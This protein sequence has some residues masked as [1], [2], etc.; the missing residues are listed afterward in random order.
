MKVAHLV[1][2]YPRVSHSFIRREILALEAMGVEVERISIRPCNAPLPDEADR[3]ESQRTTAILARGAGSLL[4]STFGT[5]FSAPARFFAA[6]Q[7]AFRL[8]LRSDRGVG[9]HLAY[10]AEACA[11]KSMLAERG[12]EHVHAHFGTNSAAVAMLCRMLGGPPFS[13]TVHGPEEFDK[14]EFLGLSEK[15]S[16][17][18]FV[19]A[20]SD[21]GRS[22]LMRWC[23]FAEWP[24]IHV[25]RC[26]VDE[27]FLKGGNP[28]PTGDAIVCVGRLCEQKGQGLLI[29]A[30]ARL[31][32]EGAS[33]R[34]ILVGDGP[35]RK[36]LEALVSERGL[37]GRVE[38]TGYVDAGEVRRRILSAR[39]LA[40]PSFAEGL[41]VVIM[42]ALALGRPVVSTYVAGI[43]ELVEPGVSG[44]LVPAGSVE[45]LVD[46]LREVLAAS[47]VRLE[48]MGRAGARKVAEQHNAATEAAR[49]AALIEQYCGVKAP[50]R[51]DVR[52]AVA[53]GGGHASASTGSAADHAAPVQ[54]G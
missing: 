46:A 53:P 23:P 10:L 26:G 7:A 15:I 5:L 44:W 31:A 4:R 2:Q 21:F 18:A 32:G 29:E 27:R 22:Q 41:P 12:V 34:L 39:A 40:L 20:V 38:I 13:F 36:E 25:V 17:A 1:N 28:G 9:R 35:M 11:L 52:R 49:L 43:P 6:L 24:K 48:G 51:G 3:V 8:G 14:P 16:R 33:F 54:A 50:A 42:E 19:V 30:A 37:E 47:D 45:R